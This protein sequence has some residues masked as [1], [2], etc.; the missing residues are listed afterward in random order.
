MRGASKSQHAQGSFIP[1][2]SRRH[3]CMMSRLMSGKGGLCCTLLRRKAQSAHRPYSGCR[4]DRREYRFFAQ[5]E[6]FRI[7][8]RP[9]TNRAS[10]PGPGSQLTSGAEITSAQPR[11]TI[12]HRYADE[13]VH[14]G[15]WGAVMALMWVGSVRLASSHRISGIIGTR[16]RTNL[17][18]CKQFVANSWEIAASPF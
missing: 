4:L 13:S 11:I 10:P 12:A 1:I 3:R 7:T 18:H 8:P 9:M 5:S 2:S 6:C 16:R 15:F 14:R 17:Q